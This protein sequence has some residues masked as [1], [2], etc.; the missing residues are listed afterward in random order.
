MTTSCNTNA[1]VIRF[2]DPANG[3]ITVGKNALITDKADIAFPGKSRL[4]YGKIFNENIVHIL[5]NFACPEDTS[6]P[7]NPNLDIAHAELLERPVYGQFW[8][9]STNSRI[10]FWDN[11]RWVPLSRMDDIAGNSGVIASGQ[12]IPLPISDVTGYQFSADECVFFVSPFYFQNEIDYFICT[13]DNNGL[14]TSQYRLLGQSDM[15][16]GCANYIVL[17][18]RNNVDIGTVGCTIVPPST[19]SPTPSM[20]VS[21]TPTPSQ[22]VGLTPTTTPSVTQTIGSSPSA[23]P[24]VTITSTPTITPTPT[25]S[26]QPSLSVGASPSVTRTP[27]RTPTVT[28]TRTP[29]N[30]IT[31]TRT[32]TVTPS[33]TPTRTPTVTPTRTPTVTPTRTPTV[34]PTRTV[35]PTPTKSPVAPLNVN[36]S[37]NGG[38]EQCVQ[39]GYGCDITRFKRVVNGSYSGPITG[40]VAP[41]SVVS[42]SLALTGATGPEFLVIS[43]SC[44]VSGSNITGAFEIRSKDCIPGT[45]PG[46]P[47]TLNV[48][49]TVTVQDSLGNTATDTDTTTFEWGSP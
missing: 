9:N 36:S 14:V 18:I 27:T 40:G 11:S 1:Y 41:Y 15:I 20:T 16:D 37:I 43:S 35:T 39:A 7:G 45:C 48:L 4:E 34:T 10:Y 28:P 12:N 47:K 22:T 38:P 2:T 3:T 6:N 19:P 31:P 44:S 25:E 8:Y 26:I 30:T 21:I 5:E 49:F 23:T 42:H 46:G 24:S 17:G 29:S 33:V 32:P 13:V